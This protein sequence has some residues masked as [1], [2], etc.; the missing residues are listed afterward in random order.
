[1]GNEIDVVEIEP[2][3]CMHQIEFKVNIDQRKI[4]LGRLYPTYPEVSGFEILQFIANLAFQCKFFI[5]VIDAADISTFYSA[6]Y[7]RSYYGYHFK[8]IGFS[9]KFL[10]KNIIVKKKTFLDCFEKSIKS[11]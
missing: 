8:G 3:T 5:D 2:G 10:F 9:Q 11:H 7:G 6:L 4:S 1:M